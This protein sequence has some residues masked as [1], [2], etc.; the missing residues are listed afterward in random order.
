LRI[1]ERRRD[2]GPA[3]DTRSSS[4]SPLG[5]VLDSSNPR[6][7]AT[8]MGL[9]TI[10]WMKVG[11]DQIQTFHHDRSH[12]GASSCLKRIGTGAG[13]PSILFT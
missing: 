10:T 12:R 13:G 11:L 2:C 9:R 4:Y 6:R 7:S 8:K 1:N 5:F 3:W